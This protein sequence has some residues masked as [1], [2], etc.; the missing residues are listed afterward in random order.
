LQSFC[1]PGKSVLSIT[2]YPSDYGKE[3]MA[4]EEKYGPQGI[5]KNSDDK[6]QD[7]EENEESD[8][9]VEDEDA[10]ENDEN[11]DFYEDIE[12][13]GS[14]SDNIHEDEDEDDHGHKTRH[15]PSDG[16]FRRKEGAVGLVMHDDLKQRRNRN[17]NNNS[18]D[19]DDGSGSM[20]SHSIRSG[21]GSQNQQKS[22]GMKKKEKKGEKSTD[23]DEIALREYELS[24]LRYYFAIAQCDSIETANILYEQLDDV[25]LGDTAMALE[26]RF[27]PD[28]L[29]L[30][31]REVRD[32]CASTSNVSH[33]YKPPQF[34]INALQHT[35]VECSWDKG[36]TEREK[37]LTN[38][39]SWRTLKESEFMQYIASSDSEDYSDKEVED[40]EEEEDEELEDEPGSIGSAGKKK[41]RENH[42]VSGSV[43][44]LKKKKRAKQLR[45]L[46]LGDNGEGDGKG[47]SDYSDKED[48]FF[49]KGGNDNDD[50]PEPDENG[51]ISMTYIPEIEKE[52]QEKATNKHKDETLTPYEL[53]LKKSQEKKKHKKETRKAFIENKISENQER[54]HEAKESYFKK[55][56][57]DLLKTAKKQKPHDEGEAMIPEDEY[58][59]DDR[60]VKQL[61]PWE[62]ERK[63]TK[64]KQI[65]KLQKKLRYDTSEPEASREE[66][67]V[68]PV[69]EGKSSKLSK[70]DKRKQKEASLDKPTPVAEGKIDV[71][72]ERFRRVFEGSDPDFG[73][74]S[75]S[76][77]FKLTKGMEKILK[78]QRK[79]REK[80]PS[81]GNSVDEGDEEKQEINNLVNKLKRKFAA[82]N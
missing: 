49:A 39:S 30:S 13:L 35:N 26:L 81:A 47:D 82:V 24:K 65:K 11:D 68:E 62:Q 77:D 69:K 42:S 28:D 23:Y 33:N 43:K 79:H 32:S 53:D 72:D 20:N 4:L 7:D 37:K 45:R 71:K 58:D 75:T 36:E 74:D 73:I 66:A 5:W 21:S 8:S 54:L 9:E 55:K 70:K 57:D 56:K 29:D 46:L 2:I 80:K 61:K 44:S 59:D 14:D 15:Q 10:E 34:V 63:E 51:E 31:S 38:I 41:N 3:R 18:A 64:E 50:F 6:V 78:E 19:G 40:E 67:G 16:D 48:D 12:D 27:V 22:V 17:R 1:P 60:I 25:E 76:T 52:L